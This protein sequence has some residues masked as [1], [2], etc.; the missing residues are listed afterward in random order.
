[1]KYSYGQNVFI[2]HKSIC[3]DLRSL[4]KALHVQHY[5]IRVQSAQSVNKNDKDASLTTE[6]AEH[7]QTRKTINKRQISILTNTPCD[8]GATLHCK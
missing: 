5:V 3:R 4:F 6:A 8:S 1:M 7:L 2:T